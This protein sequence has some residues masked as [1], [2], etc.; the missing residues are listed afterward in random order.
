MKYQI[1]EIMENNFPLTKS[2]L[3][4]VLCYIFCGPDCLDKCMTSQVFLKCLRKTGLTERTGPWNTLT[5]VVWLLWAESI[6][7][8]L[9]LVDIMCDYIMGGKSPQA[10][11][12]LTQKL[13]WEQEFHLNPSTAI[14]LNLRSKCVDIYT[15]AHP[16]NIYWAPAIS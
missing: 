4:F 7:Y 2:Q 14:F 5:S 1:R 10:D 9:I 12:V 15:L 16:A 6:F 11:I 8:N 13:L 3:H